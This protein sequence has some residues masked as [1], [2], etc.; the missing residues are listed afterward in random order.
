M[1]EDTPPQDSESFWIHLNPDG[2]GTILCICVR[3]IEGQKHD[4]AAAMFNP[5][6]ATVIQIDDCEIITV[7]RGV[8]MSRRKTIQTAA[9][10]MAKHLGMGIDKRPNHSDG[11]WYF[12]TVR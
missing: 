2:T 10:E 11:E 1:I 3:Y 9:R 12:Y 4:Y 5:A 6:P 8:G 7:E